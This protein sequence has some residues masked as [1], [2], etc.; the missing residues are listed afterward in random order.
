[1][2]AVAALAAPGAASAIE[3]DYVGATAGTMGFGGEVGVSIVPG[4]TVRAVLSG[5]DYDYETD[6]ESVTYDGSLKL[7]GFGL[8]L[9]VKPLPGVPFYVAGGAYLNRNEFTGTARPTSAVT[10]GDTTY[11]PSEIGELRTETTWDEVAP[12]LGV[13]AR[14]TVVK[15]QFSLEAGALFQGD[16]ETRV[17]STGLVSAD[18]LAR[19]AA[20]V[21]DEFDQL[22]IYP[23]VSAGLRWKF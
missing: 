17:T 19:E 4:L 9:D 10:I 7:G 6:V 21:A 2:T 16:N 8:I 12:Y 1:M 14:F 18:D 15:V 20:A 22:D 11:Q 5:L 13:G 3:L 23:V